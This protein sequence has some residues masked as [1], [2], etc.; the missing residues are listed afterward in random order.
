M[1]YKCENSI[2]EDTTFMRKYYVAAGPSDY[3]VILLKEVRNDNNGHPCYEIIELIEY[4]TIDY[5]FF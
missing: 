4:L 1:V 5:I 2:S 3:S